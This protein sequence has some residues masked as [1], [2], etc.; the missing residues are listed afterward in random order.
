M[1]DLLELVFLIDPVTEELADE[2]ADEDIS[3]SW[4]P[5]YCTA[6]VLVEPR[7]DAVSEALRFVD[8]LRQH[9][10]G[11][12]KPLQT[13]VNASAIATR[14]DVSR[15]TVS[16]WTRDAFFPAPCAFVTSPVWEWHEVRVWVQ[17]RT[18]GQVDLTQEPDALSSHDIHQILN[19]MAQRKPMMIAG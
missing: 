2:L 6:S 19:Q 1:A 8:Q 13:L 11:V 10:V 4:G 3:V 12:T 9:G 16:E 14:C 5:N 17:N 15:P 7:T 18:R